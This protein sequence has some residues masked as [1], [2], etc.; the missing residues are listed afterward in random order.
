MNRHASMNRLYRLVWSAVRSAWVPVA[1]IVRGRGKAGRNR[2][3]ALAAALS[4]ATPMAQ[5]SPGG[6]H[7]TSG[8]GSITQSGN[9]TNVQQ[10]SQDLSINWQTF[11]IAPQETVNFLQ[12]SASAI[13]VNRILGS[14]GS[15]IFGHLDA[16][17]QVYLI[18]PNGILFG[19]DSQVNVGGLVASTLD[20]NAASSSGGTKRFSGGAAGSVVN[21]GLITAANGGYVAFLGDH[22]GNTGVVM[23]RFGT[24]AL[25]AGS[26]VTLTFDHNSLLHLAIDRSVLDDVAENGG[27][28]RADGGHVVMTAGAKDALLASVVNNTGII[29]A[30]TVASH[31]GTIT[32]L[33]GASGGTVTVGGTLDASAPGGGSGGRVDT[34]GAHVEVDDQARV[35]TVSADGQYGSWLIDPQDFTVAASGGDI[36]G[37]ALSANLATTSVALNSSSGGSSGRGNVNVDAAVAWHANTSLSFNASNDVDINANITAT[38]AKAGIIIDP[39]TANGSAAASGS[40]TFNLGPSAAVN[41]PNV[42][43]ISST[44]LVIG[45]TSYTVINRLG[46]A[47]STTGTDLQGING[48]L[49]GH[50]A[51]GSNI[52]AAPTD[53]WNAGAGFTPIG[54]AMVRFSGTFDGLGHGIGQLT[55]NRPTT[56]NVGLFGILD[57]AAAVRG[58]GL[59]G[60]S[61]RG[62][63]DVGALAGLSYGSISDAHSIGTVKGAG[64]D[65]GGLVGANLGTLKNSRATGHVIGLDAP[66]GAGD[67]GGLAG[68]NAGTIIGSSAA[69][70]VQGATTG[71][72]ALV[73]SNNGGAID[74]SYATG[75]ASGEIDVGGLA[76]YNSGTISR[77]YAAGAV[78]NSLFD[79]GG[80]VGANN[81]GTVTGSWAMGSVSGGDSVGGLAGYNAGAISGSHA[82]GNVTAAAGTYGAGGLVG[83]NNGGTIDTS[84]ATGK[85]IGSNSAGGL[86]G[87]NSGAITNSYATGSVSAS[88]GA[89]G[90]GGLVGSNN[91]GTVDTSYST[92]RVSGSVDV[93]GLVGY[94]SGNVNNSFWNVTTSGLATSAAGTGLTSAQM[95]STSSFTGFHF[96]TTPGAAGNNWVIV[97]ADGSLNNAGGAMGA[98]LPMLT[99]EYSTIVYNAHQ[100][101]L[102]A[103]NTAARYVLGRSIDASGTGGGD[104]WSGSGFVPVGSPTA[105]FTGRFDGRGH[106]ISNLTIRLPLQN[107]VGLFGYL[108]MAAVVS[109]ITLVGGSVTGGNNVGELVGFNYAGTILNSGATGHVSGA[110]NVGGL[111]GDNYGG[112]NIDNAQVSG[113]VRNSYATGVV[114]GID[115][116]GGLVGY[117]HGTISHSRATG[118][119]RGANNVGGLVGFVAGDSLTIGTVDASYAT[120]NVS[121][122]ENIGGL[123]GANGAGYGGSISNSYAKGNVNGIG[124][125][126]GLVGYSG[127]V[128]NGTYGGHL[129]SIR[130]SY[131][132]GNVSAS[133]NVGGLVGL[134]GASVISDSYA[135]GTVTGGREV[136]GLVG[137]NGGLSGNFRGIGQAGTIIDSFAGGAVRGATDVGG[138]VGFNGGGAVS[139]GSLGMITDSHA[140]GRV[141]GTSNVGGLVGATTYGTVI[142]KSFATGNVRGY[143]RIGGLVGSYDI[144]TGGGVAGSG[145][146]FSG[147][148][149]NSYATGSVAGFSQVGGLVGFSNGT[150]GTS[151]AAG[152]VAGADNVGGLVGYNSGTVSNSFWDVTASG[153]STS[154]GGIG[155]TTAQMQSQANFTSATVA[156]HNINPGWDFVA[157]WFIHDGKTYPLLRAPPQEP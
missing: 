5:A 125:V 71:V 16:N 150:I 46:A 48:N 12:P 123:V 122:G 54:N 58:V 153:Q 73:G 116:V 95:L 64:F 83:S 85:V 59:M 96:T 81:G 131:A 129:G 155:M 49:A 75:S 2:T 130:H 25:A 86:A 114:D 14:N 63:N 44:A 152:S 61:V 41:L 120:G 31:D 105:P 128:Q 98:T 56:D 47:G 4:C 94:E 148:V 19:K 79:A 82:T 1:E 22:V 118:I 21:D 154:A 111:A 84:Y 15:Q 127:G 6:G 115:S 135:E 107:D 142:S 90:A 9:I 13:A 70:T 117:N 113:T 144:S 39:N 26:A 121:G 104:V 78:Q 57:T 10:S 119:V 87:Y 101:Q 143:T 66:A 92:G 99:S 133:S 151:Y 43:P 132:M 80:L 11:N 53:A 20:L 109:N 3:T 103:M 34:S 62:A 88:S 147:S 65:I 149:S 72:G 29:E 139:Y 24:V 91:G 23:A 137:Y 38:G 93:G 108:G 36:T 27:L 112:F 45:G 42:S 141:S 33:G 37:A 146:A 52:D 50:Y 89:D 97:D 124:N 28:I 134:N 100:L 102:M 145:G 40:G 60:G 7:V 126:G 138:L 140:T 32:L 17:G 18:N 51:L 68:Y 76:G 55:I 67:V 30:R 106:D 35:T 74:I 69:G 110:N 156:N 136:G 8:A 77:S 157:D